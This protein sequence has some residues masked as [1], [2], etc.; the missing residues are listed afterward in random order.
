MN[1]QHQDS[2]KGQMDITVNDELKLLRQIAFAVMLAY[3]CE[4]LWIDGQYGAAQLSEAHR[5]SEE[6]KLKYDSNKVDA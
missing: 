3:N 6:W 5:L 2:R 4:D 1:L